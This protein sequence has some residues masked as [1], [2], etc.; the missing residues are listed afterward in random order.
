MLCIDPTIDSYR[1]GVEAYRNKSEPIGASER[2]W[3]D[4]A[5]STL[6]VGS[7]VFEIGSGLGER[8][9]L[10]ESMGYPVRRSDVAPEF[11]DHLRSEPRLGPEPVQFD[12]MSDPLP[13]VPAVLAWAVLHHFPK[14]D[15]PA[16]LEKIHYYLEPQGRLVASVKAK[17]ESRPDEELLSADGLG[18]RFFAYWR[19]DEMI[20]LLAASGYA[21]I[22]V[23]EESGWLQILAFRAKAR[24]VI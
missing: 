23:D 12:L 13:T 5:F 8:S 17:T 20:D 10:V 7:E 1:Q 21:P 11:V 15:L 19:Q 18:P 16:L 9:A 2:V 24:F 4:Q 6:P 22:Q 3:L 14:A